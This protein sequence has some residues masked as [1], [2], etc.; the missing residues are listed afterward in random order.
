[1]GDMADWTNDQGMATDFEEPWLAEDQEAHEGVGWSP[2]GA[3][4]SAGTYDDEHAYNIDT[5]K[6]DKRKVKVK[7][8]KCCHVASPLCSSKTVQTDSGWRWVGDSHREPFASFKTVCKACKSP[9]TFSVQ[10]PQ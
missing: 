1:M 9:Y 3:V 6:Y 2:S 5:D 7:C 4:P 8:P 10:T